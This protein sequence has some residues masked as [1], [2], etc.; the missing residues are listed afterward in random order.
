[1]KHVPDFPISVHVEDNPLR[2][3]DTRFLANVRFRN[4]LPEIPSD[5]K[6]LLSQLDLDDMGKFRLFRTEKGGGTAGA[7]REGTRFPLDMGLSTS[8][9]YIE[10]YDVYEGDVLE[11]GDVGLLSIEVSERV[12]KEQEEGVGQGVR[13]RIK[14]VENAAWLMRTK[15][16]SSESG[17]GGLGRS[18]RGDGGQREDDIENDVEGQVRRI[19]RSFRDAKEERP[20]H[21]LDKG[22]R[23]VDVKPVLPDEALED[24]KLVLVNF[25]SDPVDSMKL[26]DP[27]VAKKRKWG[28]SLHLK[29]LKS[30]EYGRFA[31]ILA[32]RE[33]DGNGTEKTYREEEAIPGEAFLGDYEW[34]RTYNETVRV[35]ENAQT[36]L[37][38]IGDEAVQFSDLSNKLSL[39]KRKKSKKASGEID[40]V[41]SL[42][43]EKMVLVAEEDEED[44]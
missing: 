33:G 9:L 38:R 21:P 22:L 6:M 10:Q 25:D 16:I 5:P 4:E 37:F 13:K 35:D 40:G 1:M 20:V 15:Y 26:K 2:K 3:K 30:A 18:G 19:Q 7:S 11:K 39:R 14:G 42:K 12:Q 44:E 31:V 43:P 8:A 41:D 27:S 17:G 24:W 23:V 34:M 32:P 28:Q 29:T 36:Y